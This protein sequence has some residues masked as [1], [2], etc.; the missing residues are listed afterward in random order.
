[1]DFG[2]DI[3]KTD[4]HIPST[5]TAVIRSGLLVI[6]RVELFDICRT[7]NDKYGRYY[8]NRLSSNL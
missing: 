8:E 5:I 6:V 7:N 1:M 4:F 2:H 3:R